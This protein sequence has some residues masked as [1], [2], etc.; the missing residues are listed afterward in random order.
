MTVV[1]ENVE[2]RA[3]LQTLVDTYQ[4]ELADLAVVNGELLRERDAL[5]DRV[6]ELEQRIQRDAEAAR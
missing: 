2:E 1:I 3:R 4:R 6:A 5:K